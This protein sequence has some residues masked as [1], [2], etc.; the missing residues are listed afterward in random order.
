M[1]SWKTVWFHSRSSGFHSGDTCLFVTLTFFAILSLLIVYKY[2]QFKV[3]V[4]V[5]YIILNSY[6]YKCVSVL[7]SYIYK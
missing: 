5:A 4:L 2:M 1:R 6:I 7:N 3:V